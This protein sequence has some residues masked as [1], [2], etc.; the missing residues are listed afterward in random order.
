ME[1]SGGRTLMRHG[2]VTLRHSVKGEP[3]MGDLTDAV[4]SRSQQNCHLNV[5][6]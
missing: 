6:L 3:G 2:G 1:A 4:E 5:F